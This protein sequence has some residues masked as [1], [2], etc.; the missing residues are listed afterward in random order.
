M[1]A[2]DTSTLDMVA[3]TMSQKPGVLIFDI[4][5]CIIDQSIRGKSY[6][7]H[8][9]SARYHAE[10]STDRAMVSGV[11]V[12]SALMRMPNTR[13]IF[14]TSRSVSAVEYTQRQLEQM[15]G[16]NV[17]YEVVFKNDFVGSDAEFKI[18]MLKELGIK[19]AEVIVAFDDRPSVIKAYRELGIA[20]YQTAEGW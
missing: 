2:I 7:Q 3:G 10:F 1:S 11:F 8:K 13:S 6:E 4:D 9:N 19:P 20:A 18:K 14:L 5:G 15:F 17:T 16:P 12:Y